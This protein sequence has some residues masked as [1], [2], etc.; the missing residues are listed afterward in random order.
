MLP[1]Q[2]TQSSLVKS[3]PVFSLTNLGEIDMYSG[4]MQKFEL[5][6]LISAVECEAQFIDFTFIRLFLHPNFSDKSLLIYNYSPVY[7][8][9]QQRHS[10]E[11]I[12]IFSV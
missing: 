10:F 6:R 12:Y 8:G 5:R 11:Q 4:L 2:R 9:E 7:K 3:L 1:I